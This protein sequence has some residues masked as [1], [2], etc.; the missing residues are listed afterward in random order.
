MT[1]RTE[2]FLILMVMTNFFLIGSS[3]LASYVRFVAI[4]GMF[5]GFLT[6]S[7][8]QHD[9]SIRI[10]MV[11]IGNT[12]LKS[13]FFPWLLFK[14]I[15]Q[16]NIRQEIEP[17]VGYTLS[18]IIGGGLFGLSLWLAHHFFL[19]ISSVSPLMISVAFF[20]LMI[21]FFLIV[22]RNKA[23]TQVIGYIVIE[24]GI[25]LFGVAFMQE[26]PFLVELGV[27]LDLFVGVFVMQI[28]MHHIRREFESLN[29][30]HLSNLK[31]WEA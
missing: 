4:Q 30:K 19:S 2:L 14:T 9:L 8:H 21:G 10:F 16:V 25:Y 5:L 17:I 29:V 18:I 15:E 12:L 27:L 24:N 26:A 7:I 13:F 22:S 6:L 23:I 11:A 20:T 28:I 3:R 1:L 31:D